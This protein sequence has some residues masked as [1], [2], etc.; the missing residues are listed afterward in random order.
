MER[1]ESRPGFLVSAIVHLLIL[2]AL[3]ASA[4]QASRRRRRRAAARGGAP[5][6]VPAAGRGAAAVEPAGARASGSA[7]ARRPATRPPTRPA[8]TGSASAGRRPSRQKGPLILERDREAVRMRKGR[9]TGRL[10]PGPARH[11]GPAASPPPA[12]RVRPRWTDGAGPGAGTKGGLRLPP[13]LGRP[14]V[15]TR[16]AGRG[17]TGF[18]R[19]PRS[20]S[21][22]RDLDCA[23]QEL[24]P[25]GQAS[26]RSATGHGPGDRAAALRSPGGRLQPLDRAQFQNE[27]YRNWI[28]PQTGH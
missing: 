5:A 19:S 1:S 16:G 18:A 10:G 21:P 4:A 15:R 22:L 11:P 26:A 20:A 7:A 28:I 17:A 13:G 6:G 9:P 2:M 12:P 25:P 8:R 23:C 24:E 27:V 14:A 3:S